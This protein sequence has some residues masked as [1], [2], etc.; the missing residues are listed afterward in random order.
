MCDYMR[1]I[2]SSKKFEF[3]F[4]RP[5]PVSVLPFRHELVKFYLFIVYN[6]NKI[7]FT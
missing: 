5:R 2:I 1:K 6:K 7:N 4:V 3:L